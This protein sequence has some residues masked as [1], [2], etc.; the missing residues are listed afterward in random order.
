MSRKPLLPVHPRPLPAHTNPQAKPHVLQRK[1][2]GAQP[3]VIQQRRPPQAPPVYHPQ[4]P[5]KVLQP[6]SSIPHRPPNIKPGAVQTNH[7]RR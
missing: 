5:P 1:I 3:Q 6:K 7:E 2:V 4:P